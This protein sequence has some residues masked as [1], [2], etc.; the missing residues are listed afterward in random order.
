MHILCKKN[1]FARNLGRMI[2]CFPEEFNFT[3]STWI[4]PSE[5]SDLRKQ[6]EN[7]S[8]NKKRTFIVKPAASCQGRGIFLTRNIEDLTPFD[9][10]VVQ[11]YLHRPFLIDELKF[12]LRIYVFVCG[13]DP[14]RVY[15][16][17]EGL[18]RLATVKYEQPC[19]NNLSNLCM[20][21]T[22]YAINKNNKQYEKNKG[23]D[24]DD[25]GHKRSLTFTLRY[26][27]SLGHDSAKV[28]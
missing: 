15:M 12:D 8:K 23:K 2:K 24:N 5:F 26:I 7:L 9:H 22:N 17:N 21:L 19:G 28:I 20:H 16:Y 27:D 11:R 13:I 18:C 6:F 25:V 10:Y 1:L 14:L 3:P 4:L